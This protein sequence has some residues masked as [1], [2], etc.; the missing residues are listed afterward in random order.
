MIRK[1]DRPWPIP[2]VHQVEELG[3]DGGAACH[4]VELADAGHHYSPRNAAWKAKDCAVY[5]AA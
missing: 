2:L 3:K 4:G 5:A 1:H